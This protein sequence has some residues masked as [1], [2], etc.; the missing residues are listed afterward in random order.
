LSIG[1]PHTYDWTRRLV[2]T[3]SA[4]KGEGTQQPTPAVIDALARRL[5]AAEAGETTSP[6]ARVA[7]GEAAYHRLRERLAL[8]LG[9]AGFD[10]LW[11][12]AMHLAQPN[13]R[14]GDDSAAEESFP[15][16]ASRADGLYAAVRGRDS[17][18]VEHTLVIVFASFIT[19]LCTF[20]GEELSF[21]F[22]RQLWPD[23][24]P[25]AAASRAEEATS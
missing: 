15:T 1:M 24:P 20:I 17:D 16:D 22:I 7:A 11:A 19:L 23:L 12:R 4:G 13:F 21:R 5:L 25:D 18:A 2:L 10:A 9:A 3:T 14:A 6:E 8:V